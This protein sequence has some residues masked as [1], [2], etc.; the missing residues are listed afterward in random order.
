MVDPD[1]R[2]AVDFDARRTALSSSLPFTDRIT[3][4]RDGRLK[5]HLIRTLLN[6][7]REAEELFARGSYEPVYAE[8]DNSICAFVRRH[9]DK[10]VLVAVRLYPWRQARWGPL[11]LRLPDGIESGPWT[12]VLSGA[13]IAMRHGPGD[14]LG[15]LP[16]VVLRRG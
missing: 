7:R 10:A 2:R 15:T 5:Q 13:A 14:L 12:D 8:A 11:D 4:W 9:E 16:V 6:F 1:N 3:N